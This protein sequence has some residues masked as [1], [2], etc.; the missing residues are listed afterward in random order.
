VPKSSSNY[1]KVYY[2]WAETLPARR[3]YSEQ[4]V[5]SNIQLGVT[6]SGIGVLFIIVGSIYGW[7]RY[8]EKQR[9][10]AAEEGGE[11]GETP[12]APTA[13]PGEN[14]SYTKVLNQSRGEDYAKNKLNSF[15][16]N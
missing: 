12:G 1:A 4:L 9:K 8:K 3:D 11:G 14:R 7:R 5:A 2:R 16:I 15:K 10:R 13:K 6:M